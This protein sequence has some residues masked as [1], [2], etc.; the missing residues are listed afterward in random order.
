MTALTLAEME[1]HLNMVADDRSAW[2]AYSDDPVMQ[3]RLES[4]GAVL[5]KVERGG[6]KHYR[7]T[8]NQITL[9]KPPKPM[10]EERKAQSS[11][12]LA[13]ARA[14]QQFSISG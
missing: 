12:A 13:R 3:R 8:A 6:G 5:V 4:V 14:A 10:S 7:L 2:H 11:A 9:R 1:T